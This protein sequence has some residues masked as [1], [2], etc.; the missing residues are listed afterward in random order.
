MIEVL[1]NILIEFDSPLKLVR[2]IQKCLN[3]T[4][5]RVQVG[6]LLSNM[7]PIKNGFKQGEALWPLIF[8]SALQ[9]IIRRVQLIQ[10]GLKWVHISF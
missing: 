10:D 6:K 8:N 2:L 1:C 3:E 5:S 9:Y 7:F 4:H